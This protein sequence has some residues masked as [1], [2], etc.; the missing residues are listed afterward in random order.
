MSE[1]VMSCIESNNGKPEGCICENACACKFKV[2]Y[3]EAQDAYERAIKAYPH[4]GG[5]IVFFRKHDDPMGY[6]LDLD[7]L[8]RQFRAR[9]EK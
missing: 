6:N 9:C 8:K 1:K 4:W 3:L 7:G 2:E 5:N